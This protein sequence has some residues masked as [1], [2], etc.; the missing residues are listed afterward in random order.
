MGPL[1]DCSSL[2]AHNL[3]P[4][5]SVYLEPQTMTAI[6]RMSN[7]ISLHLH[8]GDEEYSLLS[9]VSTLLDRLTV[10]PS[11]QPLPGL[12]ELE[13]TCDMTVEHL[14]NNSKLHDLVASRW[15]VTGNVSR[16]SKL[17]LENYM[18]AVEPHITYGTSTLASFLLNLKD[19]GLDVVWRMNG[20]QDVLAD[21]QK[22]VES[23]L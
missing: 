4:D 21:A 2:K 19:Q 20:R 22:A 12:R 23:H 17:T 18:Q 14:F 5:V 16:L 10:T 8:L 11:Q 3:F 6:W 1:V 15:N 9:Q 7:L 13:I